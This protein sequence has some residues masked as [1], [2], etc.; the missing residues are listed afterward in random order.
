MRFFDAISIGAIALGASLFST[1]VH[2]TAIN[3]PNPKD[4]PSFERPRP[5]PTRF[6]PDKPL[7]TNIA[8]TRKIDHRVCPPTNAPQPR[9]PAPPNFSDGRTFPDGSRLP[10]GRLIHVLPHINCRGTG[11]V[12]SC[13]TKRIRVVI[14]EL[15]GL[16]PKD[17]ALDPIAWLFYPQG[18]EWSLRVLSKI[19]KPY[20]Q[21]SPLP[22][23]VKGLAT[24]LEDSDSHGPTADFWYA[25]ADANDYNDAANNDNFK[26]NI[27]N[28]NGENDDAFNM[29]ELE[30]LNK[31]HRHHKR[32]NGF[33]PEAYMSYILDEA[34][35]KYSA[36]MP[37][38]AGTHIDTK[39]IH[40]FKKAIMET[41]TAHVLKANQDTFMAE[42]GVEARHIVDQTAPAK[43]ANATEAL[44]HVL[45]ATIHS[46]E[47]RD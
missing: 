39:Q 11:A 42:P 4:I 37:S 19:I 45:N 29:E 40:A 18:I 9:S 25:G 33:S 1:P 17:K 41:F 16:L 24:D 35:A 31:L 20:E 28:D 46:N 12:S 8:G 34:E 21:T 7:F 15:S 47:G 32:H 13:G 3:I 2:S 6:R 14:L 10:D 27:D 36:M 30:M 38:Q 43:L 23:M 22:A 5:G 26:I 44:A